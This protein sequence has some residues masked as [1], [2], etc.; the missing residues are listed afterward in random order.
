ML[1]QKDE[2]DLASLSNVNLLQKHAVEP[3]M[4]EVWGS[5]TAEHV[6]KKRSCRC[7]EVGGLESAVSMPPLGYMLSLVT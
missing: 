2:D 1:A 7:Q 5:S 4:D 6:F 3:S